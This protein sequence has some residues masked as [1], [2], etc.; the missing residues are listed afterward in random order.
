MTAN[1]YSDAVQW[2]KNNGPGSFELLTL[3]SA[4]VAGGGPAS[5]LAA[6]FDSDGDLDLA[7]ANS[8]STTVSVFLN[9]AGFI[10][11]DID[12]NGTPEPDIAD[13][14]YLVTYMFQDGSEP[15]VMQACDVDGNGT[16]MPDIADLVHLV[17]YMF[18]DG[19]ALQCP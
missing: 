18:Q 7:T 9:Q 14:V 3:D 16:P 1:T 17:T 13:L 4:F 5:V 12:G 15:P 11:G 10:C 2:L 6:D 8:F 19:P